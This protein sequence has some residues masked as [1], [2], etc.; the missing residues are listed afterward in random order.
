MIV[1]SVDRRIFAEDLAVEAR[2]LALSYRGLQDLDV[3]SKGVLDWV[4]EA[5]LAAERLIRRRNNEPALVSF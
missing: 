5:D 2:K 1:D 4:T 3:G